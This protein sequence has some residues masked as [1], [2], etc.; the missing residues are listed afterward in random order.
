MDIY[1]TILRLVHIFAGILWAG[2]SWAL[3]TFVLPASQAAGPEGG[4]FMQTLTGKTKLT[5]TMFVAP[6]LVVLTGVLMYWQVSGH[7]SGPWLASPP[8]I[9]L[10]IGAAA[11]I[12]A[13]VLGLVMISPAAQRLGTLSRQ[14]Q[15]SGAPPSPAQQAELRA[16]Q[17]RIV[18]GGR[19]VAILLVI[20]VIGMSVARYL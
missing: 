18:N 3:A 4:K 17:Q 6:L 2:W 5:Q 16:I 11:G 20:A 13:F 10:T 8:G 12:L 15:S 19:Y 9:A 1:M 7:L 14:V